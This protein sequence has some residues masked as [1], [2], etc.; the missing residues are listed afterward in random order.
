MRGCFALVGC[1]DVDVAVSAPFYL[2]LVPAHSCFSSWPVLGCG[3]A[4]LISGSLPWVALGCH[5]CV[6]VTVD[7]FHTC[8]LLYYWCVCIEM[9]HGETSVAQVGMCTLAGV[10]I[11][12]M[13]LPRWAGSC[14]LRI[15]TV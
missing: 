4:V 13:Y 14:T 10:A 7:F 5:A 11:L 3:F 12:C 2:F 9:S 6:R 15:L 1:W 8:L